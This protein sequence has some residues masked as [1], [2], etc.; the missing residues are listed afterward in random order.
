MD[1]PTQVISFCF[2]MNFAH[3]F[4]FDIAETNYFRQEKV[5]DADPGKA[6]PRMDLSIKFSQKVVYK[7]NQPEF[8]PAFP[9]N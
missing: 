3:F 7:V 8:N 1:D 4:Q 9:Q 2:E 5:Y 6:Y